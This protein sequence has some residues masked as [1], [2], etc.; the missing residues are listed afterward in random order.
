MNR[1]FGVLSAVLLGLFVLVPVAAAA[2]PG[3]PDEHLIFSTGG[4]I[5]IPAG[6]HV[7]L[8]V[9]VN[10]T[11]TIQGDSDSVLLID[12]TADFVGSRTEGIVAI[13]S[14]V[15]LDAGSVVAGDIR[16]IDSNVQ[17]AAGATVHGSV[18]E[19]LDLAGVDLAGGAVLVGT[20]LLLAYVG[21]SIAMIFAALA[22]A[23]LASRQVRSAEALITQQLG[24]TVGAGL[25]GFIGIL[26]AG[27][28]AIVTIVGIPLGLGI[29]VG[30]LP[31][32]LIVG[33]LVA[34]IWIGDRIVG[35]TSSG[36]SHERPYLAAI[37]G[38]AVLSVVSLVPFVGGIASFIGFGAVVLL[39]WRVLRGSRQ[40]GLASNPS[41]APSAS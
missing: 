15:T 25:A 12:G 14:Q 28:T 16:T 3:K 32:L 20:A 24:K 13:R 29:L 19:G 2:D 38:V 40:T 27:V 30:V 5:V 8:L 7:D 1:I 23:G 26:V 6:Q 37:V 10:G 21:W 33:Y 39:M 11:A 41:V 4:D 36:S 31:M 34:G 35:R 18:L 22:L 17:Q 9:V